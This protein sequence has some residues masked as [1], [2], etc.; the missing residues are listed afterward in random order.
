MRRVSTFAVSRPILS[1]PRLLT[2]FALAVCLAACGPE[3]AE[4]PP[5]AP[6]GTGEPGTPPSSPDPTPPDDTALAVASEGTRPGS[7]DKRPSEPLCYAF[8]GPAWTAESAQNECS[9]VIGGTYG[10]ETCPTAQRIGECVYRPGGEAEREVVY[11]FY[12]PQDPL[13]AEGICPGTY[14]AF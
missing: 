11:T 10:T 7:C 5:P 2:L 14:R 1:M 9:G 8:T 13:I 4:V 12:A 6:S 3:E